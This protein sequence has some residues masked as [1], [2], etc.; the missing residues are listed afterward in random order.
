M[1][2]EERNPDD[3]CVECLLDNNCTSL[4]PKGI[5]YQKANLEI[6]PGRWV[7][8]HEFQCQVW[9]EDIDYSK[10]LTLVVDNSKIDEDYLSSREL[11]ITKLRY[12]IMIIVSIIIMML[13]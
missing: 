1:T 10:P 9:E 11:K 8:N 6:R 5:S 4:C 7:F 12:M 3:P 13:L 2:T